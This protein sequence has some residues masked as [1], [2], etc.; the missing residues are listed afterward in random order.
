MAALH[1]YIAVVETLLGYGAMVE[2][3]AASFR[4]RPLHIAAKSGQG[5]MVKFFIQKGAQTNTRACYGVQPIHEA[6]GSGSVEALDA[7]V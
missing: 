4:W 7:L 6:S 5:A 3:E 2:E 1:G